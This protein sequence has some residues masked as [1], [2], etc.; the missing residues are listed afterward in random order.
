MDEAFARIQVGRPLGLPAMAS[1][2]NIFLIESKQ[3]DGSVRM[4]PCMSAKAKLGLC[5]SRPDIVEYIQPEESSATTCTWVG[6]R[7]KGKEVRSEFTIEDAKTALLVDRG[8]TDEG[9]KANNY[10]K[11]PKIMLSWRACGRLA[12]MIGAD[13][14]LGIATREELEEE[15]EQQRAARED[16]A[17]AIARGEFRPGAV[18]AP[19]QA[20]PPRDFLAEHT[21]LRQSLTDAIASKSKPA[22]AAFRKAYDGF[23]A[24]APAELSE[25]IQRHYAEEMGKARKEAKP[26]AAS[27]GPPPVPP[28]SPTATPAAPAAA[29]APAA[30]PASPY[31]PPD[32]R[33]DSYDGPEEPFS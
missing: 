21:A 26:G 28:S 8:G 7:V 33:G 24:A 10:N 9:K 4:I 15:M 11:H 32:K 16:A 1:I 3:R 14:L 22:L 20:K 2:Q 19:P 27:N 23:K 25:D 29:E 6:K 12:D 31:L 18:E 30:K 5:L 13:I 17:D